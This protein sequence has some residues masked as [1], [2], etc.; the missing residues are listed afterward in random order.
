[1]S[2]SPL[3]LKDFA[4]AYNQA[5]VVDPNAPVPDGKYIVKTHKVEFKSSAVDGSWALS[6][7][8]KILTGKFKNR[9]LFQ[10]FPLSTDPTKMDRI[11]T[12]LAI[13]NPSIKSIEEL[14]ENDKMDSLLD[15]ALNVR[16]SSYTSTKNG[17]TYQNVYLDGQCKQDEL[18]QLTLSNEDISSPTVE[19][20]IP[21]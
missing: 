1:M 8:L 5:Q 3:N 20:E 17:R 21:F 10:Y 11:K 14:D 13:V 4:T 15:V 6:V 19:D 2:A 7:Q 18:D 12:F 9:L 16:A